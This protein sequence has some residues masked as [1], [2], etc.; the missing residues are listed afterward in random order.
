MNFGL[1]WTAVM[2]VWAGWFQVSETTFQS[3]SAM[4]KPFWQTVQVSA[5]YLDMCDVVLDPECIIIFEGSREIAVKRFDE[6]LQT[7]RA[8]TAE[9]AIGDVRPIAREARHHAMSKES[10]GLSDPTKGQ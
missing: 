1:Y 6:R 5:L 4:E 3:T 10:R 7:T 2:A 9:F 8:A